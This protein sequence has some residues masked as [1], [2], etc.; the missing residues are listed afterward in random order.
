MI[1]SASND[2]SI[3]LF[4]FIQGLIMEKE[5]AHSCEIN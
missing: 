2:Q 4:D 5:N 3:K 1:V